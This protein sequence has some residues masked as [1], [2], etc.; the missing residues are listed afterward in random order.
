[1]DKPEVG[2]TDCKEVSS[3]MTKGY[4]GKMF[5]AD[6]LVPCGLFVTFL[7]LGLLA[8]IPY[9]GILFA[10]IFVITYIFVLL[11][12]GLFINIVHASFYEEIKKATDGKIQIE[13]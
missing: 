5:L 11:V 9:V 3:A 6:I 8:Q 1:M 12:I 7:I 4:K 10:I 13:K 2:I